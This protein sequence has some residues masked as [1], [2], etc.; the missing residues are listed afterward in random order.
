MVV[1]NNHDG[2]ASQVAAGIINPVTGHRLN[3]TDGFAEFN[4]VAREHYRN[5][6]R[7]LGLSLYSPLTQFRLL[8]NQGQFDY[9]QKRVSQTEYHSIF[10]LLNQEPDFFTVPAYGAIEIQQSALVNASGLIAAAKDYLVSMDAYRADKFIYDDLQISDR[11]VQYRNI[12]A[13]RIV[14]CEGYQ[15]INNPWLKELP[16]KL[17][18]G[19]II[20]VELSNPQTNF[21]NWGSWLV[22]NHSG[23]DARLGATYEW[24]NMSLLSDAAQRQ[25]LID[26]FQKH[27]PTAVNFGV[28]QVGIR[29]TTRDRKPFIGA[30]N[31]LDHA[32]CF[33]GFG[34]KGCLTIPQYTKQFVDFLLEGKPLNMELLKWL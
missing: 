32:Y 26:S 5:L 15:A 11:C 21:L 33:N 19:E 28:S 9:Y 6:E 31:N 10:G 14:F 4:Q 20:N 16:F 18:K 1:D 12:K 2:C 3:I 30:L 25:S 24:H 27:I 7:R 8:K 29:P 13:K 22:P 34:S 17:A 23:T